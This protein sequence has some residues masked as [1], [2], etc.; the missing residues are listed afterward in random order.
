[1]FC[2]YSFLQK[3]GAISQ[4]SAK[5]VLVI[6]NYGTQDAVRQ[7]VGMCGIDFRRVKIGNT[8]NRI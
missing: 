5:N 2:G 3:T 1:M 4:W 8:P 7:D 6:Y